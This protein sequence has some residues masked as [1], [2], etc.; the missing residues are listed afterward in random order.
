VVYRRGKHIINVL[1]WAA[2][3]EHLP[4]EALYNGYHLL[5]WKSGHLAFCAVSDAGLEEMKPLT[6]LIKNAGAPVTRE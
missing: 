2:G 5:F 3:N 4:A 1:A 6:R